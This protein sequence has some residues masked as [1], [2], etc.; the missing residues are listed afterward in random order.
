MG[1]GETLNGRHLWIQNLKHVDTWEAVIMISSSTYVLLQLLD[2]IISTS[3][4]LHIY[5][6]EYSCLLYLG[7][8]ASIPQ[9]SLQ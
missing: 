9:Y 6:L 7:R 3:N 4:I 2:V 8:I 1:P 5:I